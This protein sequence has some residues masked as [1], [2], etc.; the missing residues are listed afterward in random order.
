M[1]D[2]QRDEGHGLEA[3]ETSLYATELETGDM[4]VPFIV[5]PLHGL[6][7]RLVLLHICQVSLCISQVSA[8]QDARN[9]FYVILHPQTQYPSAFPMCSLS[10]SEPLLPCLSN[11]ITG[12][13]SILGGLC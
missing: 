9:S 3:G 4:K 5:T 13:E 1:R 10:N 12:L 11:G 6:P 8:S 2:E 7:L